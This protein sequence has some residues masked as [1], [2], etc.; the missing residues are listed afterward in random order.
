MLFNIL[1]LL[2]FVFLNLFISV[3]Y[4]IYNISK[5]NGYNYFD[6]LE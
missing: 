6:R 2:I 5:Y 1:L 4:E 3:F